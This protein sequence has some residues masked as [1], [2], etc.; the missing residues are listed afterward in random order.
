[1]ACIT[2]DNR[3]IWQKLADGLSAQRPYAGRRVTI[4]GGRKHKD[5]VGT[6]IRHQHDQY[7]DAYRYG[8]DAHHHLRDLRGRSGW[9][10]LVRF[11]DGSTG[12]VKADY[13]HCH[14]GDNDDSK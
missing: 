4:V 5:K 7:S 11:D 9:V 2:S 8:N 1:M 14:I 13:T 10:C 6:V 12:W 3:D